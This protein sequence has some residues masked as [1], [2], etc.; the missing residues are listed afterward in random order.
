VEKPKTITSK[1]SLDV[2][3]SKQDADGNEIIDLTSK[4]TVV[5]TDKAPHHKKGEEVSVHPKIADLFIERGYAVAKAKKGA[6][7]DENA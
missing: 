3:K 5:M 4:K 6:S 1:P 7:E 2:P